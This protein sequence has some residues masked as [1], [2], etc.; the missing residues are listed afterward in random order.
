[1]YWTAATTMSSCAIDSTIACGG[2][3]R[4]GSRNGTVDAHEIRWRP[5]DP[6]CESALTR[7]R[8]PAAGLK[9]AAS[10]RAS[11]GTGRT[12]SESRIASASR[13]RRAGP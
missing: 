11:N 9:R 6:S 1:V 13:R 8:Q 12:R 7:V 5:H 10:M 2:S 4:G 3:W